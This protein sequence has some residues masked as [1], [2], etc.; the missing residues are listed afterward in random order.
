MTELREIY[1]SLQMTIKNEIYS[2]AGPRS[3]L[4]LRSF[5][6]EEEWNSTKAVYTYIDTI[7]LHDTHIHHPLIFEDGTTWVP[8]K[9]RH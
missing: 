8:F 6:G 3:F 2:V 5:T 9:R 7:L 1:E 4:F